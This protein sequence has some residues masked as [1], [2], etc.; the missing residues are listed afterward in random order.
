MLRKEEQ[1]KCKARFESQCAPKI[2]AVK[3][4]LEAAG[5]RVEMGD[6]WSSGGKII[7]LVD[8]ESV[9]V[10]IFPETDTY[11][12][13]LTGENVLTFSGIKRATQREPKGGFDPK[14]I[15]ARVEK[16]LAE[17]LA[18]RAARKKKI[19]AQDERLQR[20]KSLAKRSGL[21]VDCDAS[22][23]YSVRLSDLTDDQVMAIAKALGKSPRAEAAR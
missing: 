17:H 16:I 23:T 21:E 3:N 6:H 8:G 22:G 14:K 2:A 12:F 4:I 7:R 1:E 11:G 20:E 5:H 13:R 19:A 9:E 10:A 15:A 18:D